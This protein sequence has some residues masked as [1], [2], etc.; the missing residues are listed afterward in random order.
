[1]WVGFRDPYTGTDRQLS[2]IFEPIG[3]VD[4]ERPICESK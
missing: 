3:V 1:M 2:A 4:T